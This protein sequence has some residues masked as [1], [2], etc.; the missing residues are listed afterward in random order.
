MRFHQ[1]VVAGASQATPGVEA[2]QPDVAAPATDGPASSNLA[3]DLRGGR[4]R[5]GG[6]G[7]SAEAKVS[8]SL[9]TFID[10]DVRLKILQM[11][12]WTEFDKR[13]IKNLNSKSSTLNHQICLGVQLGERV[14]RLGH[15]LQSRRKRH[16]VR[17]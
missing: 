1:N 14:Q 13:N 3:Q 8:P 10:F 11:C 7:L 16:R 12:L 15:R 6:Q 9:K 2:E 17:R 5:G 4:L